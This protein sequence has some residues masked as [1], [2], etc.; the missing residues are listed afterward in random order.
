[1]NKYKKI[2]NDSKF[3]II[4]KFIKNINPIVEKTCFLKSFF[5]QN[6]KS[7]KI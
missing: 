7:F 6:L 3:I 4:N 1:M 2:F 5:I